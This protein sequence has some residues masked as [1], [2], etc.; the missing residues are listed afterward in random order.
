V[1]EALGRRERIARQERRRR[2]LNGPPVGYP[3]AIPDSRT[4]DGR[5][6]PAGIIWLDPDLAAKNDG[7]QGFVEFRDGVFDTRKGGRGHGG[8][9]YVVR[10][11]GYDGTPANEFPMGRPLFPE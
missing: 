3:A 8:G 1:A 10:I 5:P 6:I 4:F 11:Q 7:P 9:A 2:A